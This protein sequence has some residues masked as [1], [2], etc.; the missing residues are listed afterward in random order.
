MQLTSEELQNALT[1]LPGWEL[2]DG[3][4][5]REFS[6]ANF[7]EAFGFMSSVALCAER[8]NHHPEW[9]N[10]YNRVRVWLT[11]HDAG[12]LTQRDTDLAAE[13]NALYGS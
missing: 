1:R 2:D 3:K 12:G 13:M 4:L 5:Y 7:V 6:F 9:F 8:A 10:V 11:T